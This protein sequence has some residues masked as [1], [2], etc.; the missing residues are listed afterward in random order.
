M[1][2]LYKTAYPYY[3]DKKK[4]AE[5]IILKD[6]RLTYDEIKSIK[7]RISEDTDAQ[8]C[9]AV[10]M[11]VFKN[12]NHFPELNLIPQNII[13]Y[14]KDQLSIPHAE[15]NACHPSTMTRYRKRIYNYYGITPWKHSKIMGSGEIVYST[16][17]GMGKH[18]RL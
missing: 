9:Y 8:L 7:A 17:C 18:P 14:V 3:S 2:S 1:T 11:I 10:L 4:I 6:Y 5:E 16:L 15:F 13:D 12:L